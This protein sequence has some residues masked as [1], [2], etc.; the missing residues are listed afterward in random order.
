MIT[1][2]HY[3]TTLNIGKNGKDEKLRNHQFICH[4]QYCSY[5]SP[6]VHENLVLD[7][8]QILSNVLGET[9]EI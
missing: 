6:N 5:D 8:N 2:L 7:L 3:E 9:W 1:N 4:G